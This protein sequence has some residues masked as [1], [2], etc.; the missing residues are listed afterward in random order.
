MFRNYCIKI[1]FN[2]TKV[3][4]IILFKITFT[5]KCIITKNGTNFII[6]IIF[7]FYLFH[8]FLVKFDKVI[9]KQLN[10]SFNAMIKLDANYKRCFIFQN[11]LIFW[12]IF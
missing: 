4:S 12:K 7:S 8:Y 5:F 10:F 11:L 2:I 9:R 1:D 6:S 3:V